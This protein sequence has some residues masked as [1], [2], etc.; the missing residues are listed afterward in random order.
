MCSMHTLIYKR[1]HKGDPDKSG[2]FG[3]HDCMG[4]VR[5]CNFDSVIGVGVK[6]PWSGHEDIALKINW[7]GLGATRNRKFKRGYL[8]TFKH[9]CLFEERGH[10]F[11]KWAPK[12]F[13]HMFVDKMVR[14]VLS[15]SISDDNIQKEIAKILRIAEKYPKS[16]GLPYGKQSNGKCTGKSFKRK[17][18]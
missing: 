14:F 5:N 9:F 13:K 16:R 2:T 3:I 11:K 6:K 1:T 8:I 17:S 18:K 15:S 7:I 12:L 4:R 10:D